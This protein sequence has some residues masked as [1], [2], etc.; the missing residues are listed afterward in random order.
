MSMRGRVEMGRLEGLVQGVGSSSE[1]SRAAL[2]V[3]ICSVGEVRIWVL[4]PKVLQGNTVDGR[5]DR[6]AQLLTEDP[7]H[8]RPHHWE[9]HRGT[10]T[11]NGGEDTLDEVVEIV[12]PGLEHMDLSRQAAGAGSLVGDIDLKPLV[13]QLVALLPH[14]IEQLSDAPLLAEDHFLTRD[15]ERIM[16][17]QQFFQQVTHPEA[18]DLCHLSARHQAV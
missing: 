12:P 11:V 8:I 3:A 1:V 13:V 7:P 17:T 4:T 14:S 5:I 9:D 15:H 18:T 6:A 2:L 10:E 16:G